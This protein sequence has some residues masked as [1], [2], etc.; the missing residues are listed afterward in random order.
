ML[1]DMTVHLQTGSEGSKVEEVKLVEPRV[2]HQQNKG[3]LSAA[4]SLDGDK[5]QS[6]WA[7]DAGGIGK[8]QAVLFAFSRPIDSGENGELAITIRCHHS[9]PRHV[10]GRPRFSVTSADIKTIPIIEKADSAPADIS[11]TIASLRGGR[12]VSATDSA[13]AEKWFIA[14]NLLFAWGA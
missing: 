11:A 3:A 7:V 14:R 1:S 2:T 13:K 10:I 4:A 5:K 6:G 8:D 12:T 9:N